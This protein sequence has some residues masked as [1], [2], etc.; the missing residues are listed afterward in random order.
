MRK[1]GILLFVAAL[2]CGCGGK[3]DPEIIPDPAPVLTGS[4]PENNAADIA[5]GS[6]TITLSFDQMVKC[7]EKDRISV[8]DSQVSIGTV[9]SLGK[10]ITIELSGL[11][12]EK[13]YTVT[14]PEGV[15]IGIR[16]NQKKVQEIKLSFTTARDF[17]WWESASDAVANMGTGWNLGNTLDSNS[18]D[19]TSSTPGW[20]AQYSDGTPAAW[21][22]AW[23]QPVTSPEL[24][25]M[26]ADAGF[27]AIRVPV[28]WAEHMD[29][30]GNVDKAWMDRV[31]QVVNY[32]LD[33]GMYCIIN[34]HHDTGEK[35]WLVADG[36]YYSQTYA[37]FQKLWKQ[38]AER[39][40]KYGE[41]LLFESFNEMLDADNHWNTAGAGAYETIY[42]YN[43]DFVNTVRASGGNNSNRNLIVNT[44]AASAEASVFKAFELPEDSAKDHLIAEF[45][46]YAP[47]EFAFEMEDKSR[48]KT[49]FDAYCESVVTQIM[50][51]AYDNLVKRGIPV[52]V[53]E[54]GGTAS[55]TTE[56]ELAKQAACYVSN[57][58]KYGIACFY[59]MSLSDG[60]DRSVP[61]WTRPLLKQAILNAFNN[62]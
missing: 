33:A 50:T 23:G 13:S 60:E 38:I 36:N 2:L 18:Y 20:I 53:G 39:F 49:V 43:T 34:V 22:T 54:Y 45:H 27:G 3:D 41:K 29:N 31:E 26:F 15:I 47:Y 6:L 11:K 28:T 52:I 1:T 40:N 17:S 25:K 10:D 35:G 21:E 14:I 24:L 58:R 5:A 37:K 48:Q 9:Q 56:T 42:K 7:Q 44:Y 32:V 46:S 8:N 55:T 4:V 57:G 19:R 12:L 51:N 16:K 61:K 59:W 30:A 62:Q